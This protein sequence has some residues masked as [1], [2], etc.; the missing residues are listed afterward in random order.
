MPRKT[1]RARPLPKQLLT[2]ARGEFLLTRDYFQRGHVSLDKVLETP[3]LEG[4]KFWRFFRLK[5]NQTAVYLLPAITANPS[6]SNTSAPSRKRCAGTRITATKIML[7][8][9]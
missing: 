4:R 7:C 5:N 2:L 1:P 3:K 6:L 8:L 9:V